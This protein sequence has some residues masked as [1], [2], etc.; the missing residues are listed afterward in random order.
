M[1]EEKRKL[2]LEVARTLNRRGVTPLLYGSLGLWRRTGEPI[3]ADDIDVL[4]PETWLTKQWS[5]F[6]ALLQAEDWRLIDAHE[7]TFEKRGVHCSFAA[8]EE[9][10]TF[11]GV[12]I[13]EIETRAESGAK[14]RLLSVKQYL[15]VY[16]A[17]AKDGYRVNT[18]G[19]KDAE[20][21]ALL[22]K[23]VRD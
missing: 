22:E 15:A 2:F 14:Y 12:P 23:L 19:K 18:R 1:N 20:K 7:H 9:L 21:I 5:A 10:E 4:L 16:K 8:L 17:S 11:A 13:S 3:S 6:Q